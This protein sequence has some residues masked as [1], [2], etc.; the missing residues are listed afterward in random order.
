MDQPANQRAPRVQSALRPPESV[1]LVGASRLEGG[2]YYGGRL[3]DNVLNAGPRARI[4]PVNPRLK[5][6]VIRGLDVHG[7]LSDLPEV[8]E[9]VVITSPVATVVPVLEEAERLG[10]PSCVIISA[11]HGG[12]GA[13]RAF[14]EAVAKIA[15]RSG[16][17]II[18]PNSMGVFNAQTG[19]IA[20][21]SSATHGMQLP[22]GP[23]AVIAQSGAVISY[24]LQ[25]FRGRSMGYSWL[26]SSGNEAGVKLEDLLDELVA[27]PETGVILLFVEGIAD[28]SR[29]RRAALRARASGKAVVMMNVGVSDE[30]RDAVQSHTGRIAGT[31]EMVAALADEADIHR[32][33]SYEELFDATRGIVEQGLSRAGVP[34]GR[35]AAVLTTSG[36]AGSVAADQLSA[37]GW[38]LPPL[39]PETAEALAAIARQMHAGNP[40]DVT[41]A[42]ADRPMLA[43]MLRVLADSGAYDALFL[44]SGAGGQL[45]VGIAEEIAAAAREFAP[46]TYVA[47]IGLQPDVAAVYEGGAATV[48]SDSMRAIR[49]ASASAAFR[50]GQARRQRSGELLALIEAP[51]RP[52]PGTRDGLWT[53][54]DSMGDVAASGV[55]CAPFAVTAGMDPE[56]AV[57]KAGAVGLPVVLKIDAASLSHKSDSGGVRLRLADAGAV[58]QAAVELGAIAAR[59]GVRDGRL[60]VQAMSSGVEVLVGVKQEDAFGPLLVLGLGGTHAELH[61]ETAVSTLLPTDRAG[62]RGLLARHDKLN[63]LLDGYRGQPA[64]SREALLDTLQAIADWAVAKGPALREADFNPVMVDADSALVVDARVVMDLDAAGA[65]KQ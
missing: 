56:E 61:A 38:T 42:F 60:L 58:R 22:P 52:A 26:V 51:R 27:D 24:L 48:F 10:V 33:H 13:Q 31:R 36:G 15:A 6:E 8:P 54:A 35:R 50:A 21:F 12:A 59:M 29:L 9:L 62:L 34:H 63:V 3:L 41:G 1:A 46:E 57:A 55:A 19:L 43:R 49:A 5:G 20:S 11:E 14:D 18:G 32:V 47:W 65:G 23:V 39:P 64:G 2:S 7:T 16:M 37:A 17:R 25:T 53:A 30:G 4:Y 45:A 28:G 44:V 40:V